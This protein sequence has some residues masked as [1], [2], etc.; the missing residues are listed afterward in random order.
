MYLNRPSVVLVFNIYTVMDKFSSKC[1]Y[2]LVGHYSKET[3]DIYHLCKYEC[4]IRTRSAYDH[5]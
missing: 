1:I 5:L 2:L 3:V 4:A